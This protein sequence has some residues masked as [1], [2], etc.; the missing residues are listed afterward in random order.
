MKHTKSLIAVSAMAASLLAGSAV[1]GPDWAAIERGRAAKQAEQ[2]EQAR[3]TA[4]EPGKRVGRG[5]RK[6]GEQAP[7]TAGVP[8]PQ[9]TAAGQASLQ[10]SQNAR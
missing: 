4:G 7:R 5:Q 1:A 10:H 6:R 9:Q 8:S 2:G 3:R